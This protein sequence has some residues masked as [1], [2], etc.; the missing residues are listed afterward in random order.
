LNFGHCDLL[1]AIW[2]FSTKLNNFLFDHTECLQT[3]AALSPRMKL[4]HLLQKCS[5]FSDQTGRFIGQWQCLYETTPKW[6]GFF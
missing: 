1:F 5:F 4:H 2:N 3:E 6:H